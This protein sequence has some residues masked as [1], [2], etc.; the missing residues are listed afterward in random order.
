V[1]NFTTPL[2]LPKGGNYWHIN[3]VIRGTRLY[4][5]TGTDS[6]IEAEL[7]LAKRIKE[8]SDPSCGDRSF[9]K[10]A[11]KYLKEEDKKVFHVMHKHSLT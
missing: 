4:E 1:V 5:S 9:I 8:L 7:Y 3:K 2:H 10:A 11:T 6:L